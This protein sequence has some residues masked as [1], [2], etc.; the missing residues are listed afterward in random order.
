MYLG[1]ACRAVT[2][3]DKLMVCEMNWNLF[4]LKV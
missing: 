1:E 3:T 4:N 2:L